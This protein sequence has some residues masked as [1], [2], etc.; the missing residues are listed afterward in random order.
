M[1]ESILTS[2]KMM[3]GIEVSDTTFDT[4]VL[5]H[6]NAA[7]TMLDQL[8]LPNA[9]TFIVNDDTANW[10]DILTGTVNLQN[11]KTFVYNKV[12]LGF[13][14]PQNSFLVKAIEDQITELG[15]RIQVSLENAISTFV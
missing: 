3:L 6:I 2:L 5:I 15:W 7:F 13:D 8:G 12:R 10:S 9:D 1:E 4:E 14:P 11:V